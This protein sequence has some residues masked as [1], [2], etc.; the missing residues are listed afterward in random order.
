MRWLFFGFSGRISRV[1]YV[2]GTLFFVAL[3]SAVISRLMALPEESG[4]FAFWSLAFV[5]LLPVIVW[6]S[7]ALAVKRLHDINIPGPV[8]ICLF[9]PAV[10]V[11]AML[12]LCLWPGNRGGNDYG[13]D[14]NRPK[15]PTS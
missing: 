8:A 7:I 1:P 11:L 4:Q 12:V 2:L 15:G 5:V 14:T 3:C 6:T 10:S 13:A 9:V